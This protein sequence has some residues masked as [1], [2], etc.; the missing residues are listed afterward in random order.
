MSLPDR[1]GTQ[2]KFFFSPETFFLVQKHVV[3]F[4]LFEGEIC[5]PCRIASFCL[6]S[7][8]CLCRTALK[9]LHR[10]QIMMSR[11]AGRPLCR[12]GLLAGAS[13]QAPHCP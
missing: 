10:R 1:I 4:P 3:S 5:R 2:L 11:C 9:L 12:S 7:L 6:I 8:A 13:F